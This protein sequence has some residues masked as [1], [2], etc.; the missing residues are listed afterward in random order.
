MSV[1]CVL[2]GPVGRRSS[3]L[4]VLEKAGCD[5][6]EQPEFNPSHGLPDDPETGWI[7]VLADDLAPIEKAL[8]R[9]G[10]WALRLHWNTPDCRACDGHGKGVGGLVCLHCA[11][12]GTT[13]KPYRPPDPLDEMRARLDTLERQ[14]AAKGG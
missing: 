8:A 4:L 12:R 11:G 13:N 7:T 9:S 2:S 14:L 10:G 1:T 6:S 5:L 3:L